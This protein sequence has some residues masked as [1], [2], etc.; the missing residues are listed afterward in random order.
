MNAADKKALEELQAY[1]DSRTERTNKVSDKRLIAMNTRTTEN[2]SWYDITVE[3]NRRNAKK[4]AQASA[5]VRT[6]V[7]ISE[8]SKQKAA[9]TRAKRGYM[10]SWNKGISPSEATRQKLSDI[11]IGK[12]I[13]EDVKAKISKNSARKKSIMTPEGPFESRTLAAKHYFNNKLTSHS[14]Y[15]SVGVWMYNQIKK[16]NSGFYYL[17]NQ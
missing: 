5:K 1:I 9:A 3:R 13:P 12:I 7:P 4:G 10:P 6:G 8:E 11:N 15:Q 16:K 17:G 2:K 14:S